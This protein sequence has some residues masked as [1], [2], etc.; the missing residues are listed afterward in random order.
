M[1]T[2][3]FLMETRALFMAR[4]IVRHQVATD[5]LRKA[6]P[7]LCRSDNPAIA[8]EAGRLFG[9]LERRRMGDGGDGA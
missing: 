8:T 4:Q 2:D 1:T 9:A 6:L 7:T 3:T 5:E